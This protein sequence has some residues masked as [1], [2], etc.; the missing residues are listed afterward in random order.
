MRTLSLLFCLFFASSGWGVEVERV[1]ALVNG[2][3]VLLSD[4]ELAEIANLL[5]RVPGEG[6]REYHNAVLEALIALE[7][8][9]QDLKAAHLDQRLVVDWEAAWDKVLQQVGGEVELSRRLAA[10]GL[11]RESLMH[12]VRRAALVEA[13]VAQRFAS[14][15]RVTQEEVQKAYE[16]AFP[17]SPEGSDNRP[18]LAEVRPQLERMIRERKLSEA[19]SRWTQELAQRGEVLRYRR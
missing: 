1:L 17:P 19:V 18:L 8:R 11:S 2:V 15:L 13:Y 4:V 14:S 10:A 9:Y 7:L 16:A 5:P 3:P 6:E 12:L